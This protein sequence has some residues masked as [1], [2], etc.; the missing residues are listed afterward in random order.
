MYKWRKA[1]ALA[2][3]MAL[4]AGC[5][6]RVDRAHFERIEEGMSQSEVVAILGEP[7]DMESV[8]LGGVSGGSATWRDGDRSITVVFANDR[9][10]LKR[11][12]TTTEA[13]Q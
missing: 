13:S 4:L 5:Q 8:A 10:T 9:V 12:G 11:Y 7:D 6:S 1:T 3:L 2:V